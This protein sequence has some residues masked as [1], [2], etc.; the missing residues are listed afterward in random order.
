MAGVRWRV[1]YGLKGQYGRDDVK[2]VIE[3]LIHDH[4]PL[5]RY[6]AIINTDPKK[7]IKELEELTHCSDEFVAQQAAG[8]LHKAR[9]E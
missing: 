5:V 1:V 4:S 3:A 2:P 8:W 7:H 6:T 9:S